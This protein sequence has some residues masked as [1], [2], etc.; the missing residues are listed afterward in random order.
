MPPPGTPPDPNKS[1]NIDWNKVDYTPREKGKD[2]MSI[3]EAVMNALRQTPKVLFVGETREIGDWSRLLDFAGTGHLVVTTAH[4]GSLV[5]AMANLLRAVEARRPT[6][7]S[8]VADRTL[9]LIH[10]RAC[11][12]SAGRL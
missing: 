10:L 2:A 4:A 3:K 7:R 1:E 12:K 11:F 8:E 6:K 5:E 9:A